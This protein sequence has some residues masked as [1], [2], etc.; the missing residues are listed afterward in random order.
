[1][2]RRISTACLLLFTFFASSA[3]AIGLLRDAEVE[4]GLREIAAPILRAAGLSTSQI[5]ILV[6]DD[7][8][9]NAFVVNSRAIFINSGLIMKLKRREQLQAVIGHEAAHIANGHLTRRP[10][11]ARNARTASAVGL[12]LSIAAG[13]ATGNAAI[14]AGGAIGSRSS[15]QRVFF[16]HTRSEENSA[17]QSSVRFMISAGADPMAAA[18]VQEFFAGK[19]A[20]N[21]GRQ[22]PYMQ[23]H[24]LTRDRIRRMRSLAEANR[25]RETPNPKLDQW[26]EIVKGKLTA[27]ELSPRETLRQ[28]RGKTDQVSLMRQAVA[29]HRQPNVKKASQFVDQLVRK[30]PNNPY[31]HEL[32]GQILL[33]NRNFGGAANAYGKAVQLAPNN[34]LIL[35][36]YGRALLATNTSANT[37][38]ALTA[39]QKSR[40]RDGL[41]SKVMRDLG[42]AYARLGQNGMASLVTA[43][44]YATFGQLCNAGVHARRASDLL[45]RGSAPWQRA[46]DVVQTHKRSCKQRK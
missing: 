26:F 25:G 3:Q 19:I 6:V 46:M 45:Q 21:L 28:T 2:Q 5:N 13:A 36:G 7:R 41:D 30:A 4:R 32:R 8:R 40:A 27:F 44:R 24:P 43:E 11:N 29:Y 34:P 18:E 37:K 39:L 20:L 16:G 42:V 38:R 10:V 33:E 17:D 9:L 12:A 22:D 35:G 14:A 31:V 23:S 1:M 15:A